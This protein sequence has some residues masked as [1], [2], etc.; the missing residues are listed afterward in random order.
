MDMITDGLYPSKATAGLDTHASAINVAMHMDAQEKIHPVV[1][2]RKFESR[3]NVNEYM[4]NGNSGELKEDGHQRTS[5]RNNELDGIDHTKLTRKDTGVHKQEQM[6]A[7][8]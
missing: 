3:E 2:K 6:E 7:L 8:N 1:T 5:G 4:G